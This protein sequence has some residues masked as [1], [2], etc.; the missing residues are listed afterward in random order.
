MRWRNHE[1]GWGLVTRI[2][3]WGLALIVI[4]MWLVGQYMTGL[5]DTALQ[6]KFEL[7]QL[8]KS[9]GVIVFALA[10]LR[11]SWRLANPVPA[12]PPAMPRLERVAAR[13]SHALFYVFLLAMPIAGFLTAAS[14]PLGIPT[15]VFGLVPL[16]HPIGPDA[17]LEAVFKWVHSTAAIGL[18]VLLAVHVAA[19]LKHQFLDRDD[20]LRRMLVDR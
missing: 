18:A 19:A 1:R 4:G 7:Y 6:Q 5:P 3:H 20:V 14:S 12:F 15:V 2:L 13:A 11:L 16:P 8:H 9:F 17:R 10:L